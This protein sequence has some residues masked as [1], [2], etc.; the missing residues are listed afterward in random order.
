MQGVLIKADKQRLLRYGTNAFCVM[1]ELTGK[2]V[3]ELNNGAGLLEIRAMLYSGLCWED[4]ELTLD[5]A[6][7]ILDEFIRKDELDYITEKIGEATE[8]ALG[9][10][11]AKGKKFKK[12]KRRR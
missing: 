5:K 7:D 2:S 8:Q 10:K 11:K 12:K 4:K 1:E 3:M 9:A 6:G